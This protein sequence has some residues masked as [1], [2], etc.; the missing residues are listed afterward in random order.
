MTEPGL[1]FIWQ[2]PNLL[3]LYLLQNK[4]II[5]NDEKVHLIGDATMFYENI[6]ISS[7]KIVFNPQTG[8]LFS[9]K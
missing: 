8:S 5:F 7:D 4:I 2:E 9:E 1:Y 3:I 6:N